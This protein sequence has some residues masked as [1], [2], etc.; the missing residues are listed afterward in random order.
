V[1][2]T[3]VKRFIPLPQWWHCQNRGDNLHIRENNLPAHRTAANTL[4]PKYNGRL[5]IGV[6]EKGHLMI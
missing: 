3:D 1:T 4:G 5:L 6:S 2:I